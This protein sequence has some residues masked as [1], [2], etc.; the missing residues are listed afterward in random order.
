MERISL[1]VLTLEAVA[2]LAAPFAPPVPPHGAFAQAL[3]EML[4]S[5]SAATEGEHAFGDPRT[6]DVFVQPTADVLTMLL[7]MIRTLKR[8]QRALRSKLQQQEQKE[9]SERDVTVLDR[10]EV[11]Y[12]KRL[13][14]NCFALHAQDQPHASL[15]GEEGQRRRAAAAAARELRHEVLELAL[16]LVRDEGE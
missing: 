4:G 3:T 8:E 12:L 11:A 2:R 1:A 10:G 5:S 16:A 14:V 6:R 7:R 15:I 13:L 9:K